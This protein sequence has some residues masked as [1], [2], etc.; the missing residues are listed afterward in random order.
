MPR[1]GAGASST[2][3]VFFS[4]TPRNISPLFL[5]ILARVPIENSRDAG[6]SEMEHLKTM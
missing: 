6:V 4:M 1:S 2:R 3:R 5:I